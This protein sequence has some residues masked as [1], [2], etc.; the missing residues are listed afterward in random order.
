M[1]R[2][3]ARQGGQLHLSGFLYPSRGFWHDQSRLSLLL[4]LLAWFSLSCPD[5]SVWTYQSAQSNSQLCYSPTVSC[6]VWVLVGHGFL[7]IAYQAYLCA[8]F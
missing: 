5:P 4:L 8:R 6:I 3:P 1:S 7:R 2:S